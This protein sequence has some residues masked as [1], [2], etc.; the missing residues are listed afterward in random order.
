M[1]KPLKFNYGGELLTEV[2]I[3]QRAY[4]HAKN[5]S[6]AMQKEYLKE[7]TQ[8]F[9]NHHMKNKFQAIFLPTFGVVFLLGILFVAYFTPY[10]SSFQSGTFW[11]ALCLAAA[12]CAALI[13]G[14]IEFQY[15]GLVRAGGAIAIFAIMYFCSPDI[16]SKTNQA[17]ST[18][19]ALYVVQEDSV[20][21]QTLAPE[22]D[23]NSH[24]PLAKSIA[25]I[26]NNYYGTNF[27]PA[28]YTIYR[29]SDGK[30]YA[31]EACYQVRDYTFLIIPNEVI[32]HYK[33]KHE[34]YLKFNKLST[35]P[36]P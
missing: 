2:E 23:V 32:M 25:S 36:A 22:F 21:V 27:Q 12:A 9:S 31:E 24:T 17:V 13:P 19:A 8:V 10:P 16:I 26:V 4:D 29:K 11:V 20:N 15:Q 6:P 1:N 5:Y 28:H 3:L 34:A 35:A 7:I 33:N 18:K 30:I 14:F